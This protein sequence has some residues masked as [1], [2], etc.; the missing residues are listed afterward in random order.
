MAVLIKN[1]YLD[2]YPILRLVY[3]YFIN[4]TKLLVNLSLPVHWITPNGVEIT[5]KY[6]KS[7]SE[8]VN[9]S[10]FG[11]K[12]CSYKRMNRFS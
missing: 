6:L 12:N 4:V 11:K 9:L 8:K 10:Y 3:N 7:K 5:P 2:I 1:I